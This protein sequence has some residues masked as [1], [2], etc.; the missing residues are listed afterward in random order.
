MARSPAWEQEA[1]RRRWR[2]F[3]L[4]RREF[5]AFLRTETRSIEGIIARLGLSQPREVD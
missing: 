3:Y 5:E 4:P 2:L 1:A